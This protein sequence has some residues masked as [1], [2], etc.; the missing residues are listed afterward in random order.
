MLQELIQKA[1]LWNRMRR[2]RAAD[3]RTKDRTI[4]YHNWWS[5]DYEEEWFHR[6]IVNNIGTDSHTFHFFSVFGPREMIAHTL[7][8]KILCSGENLHNIDMD[9]HVYRDYVLDAMDLAMGFDNLHDVKYLRF[10]LWIPYLFPP[11]VDHTRIRERINEINRA[12]STCKHDCALIASHDKWGTRRPIYDALKDHMDIHCA[13]RWQH[14]T[15]ALWKNY[16]N[17]K[18]HYL[19]DF[20]FSICPENTNTRFYVTEKLFEALLAGTIPIYA[21]GDNKPET[22][23]VNSHAVL[24]W[25]TR[26]TN[27]TP[28]ISEI[29]RLQSDPIYYS[30]F[31]R[32]DKLL[33]YAEEYVYDRFTQLKN[34]L[35]RI[36]QEMT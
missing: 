18:L 22:D 21:G 36:R 33:P 34:H 2:A 12:K 25:D 32:Q 5:C 35:L 7:G 28:L 4:C 10:P 23:I 29:K 24:L 30:K 6:F 9:F 20:R 14:N 31:I 17:N 16:E 8:K 11:I 1:K 19:A 15:D 26:E 13:G 27:H 3:Y